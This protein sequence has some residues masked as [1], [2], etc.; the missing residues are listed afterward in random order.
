MDDQ[1]N[2]YLSGATA[3]TDF[4]VTA[5]AYQKTKDERYDAFVA[6]INPTGTALVYAT[7]LGGNDY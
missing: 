4:P 1:G 6:K 3:S 5:T 7:L 2:A